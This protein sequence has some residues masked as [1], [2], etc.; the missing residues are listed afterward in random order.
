LNADGVPDPET[1]TRYSRLPDRT[2]CSP[3]ACV[4]GKIAAPCNGADDHATCDSSPG[5]GDGKCDACPITGGPTTEDEMFVLMPWYIL[6][7]GQ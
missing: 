1:V 7:E 6:P 4:S 2:Q 3:V 5:A